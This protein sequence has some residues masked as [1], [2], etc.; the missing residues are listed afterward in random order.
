MPRESPEK[1]NAAH[2][3]AGVARPGERHRNITT[4]TRA[5]SPGGVVL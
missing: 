4:T 3:G 1:P 5:V 2:A